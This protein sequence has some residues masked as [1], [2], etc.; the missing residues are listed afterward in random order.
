MSL[1]EVASRAAWLEARKELL[2]REKELTRVRDALNADR[3]RLPMVRI[4]K[5][6]AFE[7]PAGTA[8]LV[9]LFD[10]RRQLIIQ[11]FMF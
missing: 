1:P 7:G 11:H 2:Q 10:G 6:Y 5:E 9:D 4:E 3:R 8:S